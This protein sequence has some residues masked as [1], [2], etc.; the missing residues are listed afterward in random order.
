[1]PAG[2]EPEN[3]SHLGGPGLDAKE[4]AQ[5]GTHQLTDCEEERVSEEKENDVILCKR[6]QSKNGPILGPS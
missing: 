4:L 6:V 5:T 3:G 1:M 2:G